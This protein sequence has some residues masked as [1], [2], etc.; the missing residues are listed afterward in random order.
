MLASAALFVAAVTA[1]CS[2]S[3]KTDAAA[4][5]PTQ[6][7][8]RSSG[9]P[10]GSAG[11]S[12]SS[13]PGHVNSS[14]KPKLS[15]VPSVQVRTMPPVPISAPAAFGGGV[16]AR[17]TKVADQ[18]QTDQGPGVIAGAPAVAFTLEFTN[19]SGKPISVNTVNVTATYG[20]GAPAVPANLSSN[21]PLR[22]DIKSGGTATG[23]Y[24]FVIPRADRA[25][26]SLAV[27]YAQGKPTVVFSGAVS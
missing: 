8:T 26:V 25:K 22:N 23:V 13:P 24:A 1:G 19:H 18:K 5:P 7:P 14:G 6:T 17:V 16:S 2:H 11:S 20:H 4:S 9:S 3:A 21:R 15:V 27:W 12:S 10:I